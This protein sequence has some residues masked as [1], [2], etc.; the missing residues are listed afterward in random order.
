MSLPSIRL[1]AT[2]PHTFHGA[3]TIKSRILHSLHSF[4]FDV[5]FVGLGRPYFLKTHVGSTFK[6]HEVLI[7]ESE[8]YSAHAKTFWST[9]AIAEKV[10][11]LAIAGSREG[12][13]VVFWGTYLHPYVQALCLANDYLSQAGYARNPIISFP[14]GSDIWE[15]GS[16]VARSVW[17]LLDS[18]Q[19]TV[20][21]TYSKK[22][23]R[24]IRRRHRVRGSFI[25]VPPLLDR[26]SFPSYSRIQRQNEKSKAGVDPSA[27][28][29][30][31][32]SN[33]RPVKRI[34]DTIEL[35]TSAAAICDSEVL[36]VIV[37]PNDSKSRYLG[38]LQFELFERSFPATRSQN[39]TIVNVGIEA[40][41]RRY[42]RIADI[43]VNTSVH[44]SFNVSL[45][46]AVWS[47]IACV[48]SPAPA[49]ANYFKA[50]RCALV[51]S[52]APG[53]RFVDVASQI[54]SSESPFDLA[55]GAMAFARMIDDSS[56]REHL[57][58]SADAYLSKYLSPEI[59]LQRIISMICL[60]DEA[61]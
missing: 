13:K 21:A 31:H 58:V 45:L 18:Q 56:Y 6:T 27:V 44:D 29:V 17:W 3:G 40:D 39:L 59:V 51:L 48:T 2:A 30:L 11:E 34:Q 4:G 9:Y 12:F 37:G 24:E 49:I 23:V 32:H 46:E 19:I 35:V 47:G 26:S 50:G 41:V 15:S 43:A 57:A 54:D 14:A 53:A 33:L 10:A 61:R 1:I 7:P 5:H 22:F 52:Y 28:V 42:L 25:V 16:A 36:L 38:E 8:A 55:G 20:R 60:A